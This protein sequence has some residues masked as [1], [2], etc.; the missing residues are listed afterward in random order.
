MALKPIV[1][2]KSGKQRLGKGFSLGELK[3]AGLSP[4]QA[5]KIGIPA[6]SRRRTTHEENVKALKDYISTLKASAKP[7][8]RK[9]KSREGSQ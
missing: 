6:D 2:K 8:R 5:L 3:E 7:K 4:K 1:Q 9:P